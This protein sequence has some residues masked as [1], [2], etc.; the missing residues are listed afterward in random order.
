MA[1]TARRPYAA[2]PVG[3][4]RHGGHGI[5]GTIAG[6]MT[7]ATVAAGGTATVATDVTASGPTAMG[8]GAEPDSGTTLAGIRATTMGRAGAVRGSATT[9]TEPK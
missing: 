9:R 6:A 4:V 3:T 2:V 1:T 7:A 5:D 8:M